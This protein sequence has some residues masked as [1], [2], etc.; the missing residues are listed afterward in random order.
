MP[1][2]KY[3]TKRNKKGQYDGVIKLEGLYS[4][5]FLCLTV[6]FSYGVHLSPRVHDKYFAPE[7]QAS[8]PIIGVEVNATATVDIL[9]PSVATQ[10]A[11]PKTEKEEVIE[12]IVEVF[13]EDSAD[14][15]TML[16]RCENPNFSKTAT[17]KNNN[18]SV[19]YS[20]MQINDIHV[21]RFGTGFMTDWKENVRVARK[22][23]QE[24]G[25][26]IWSCSKHIGVGSYWED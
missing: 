13:G 5:G 14:A 3:I 12:Y 2:K 21:K 19:D 8:E 16:R 1:R 26:R 9:P 10:S 11:K 4:L 6:L 17:N 22:L 25:W 24:Q 15:I 7:V 23:Q 20:P 18:G